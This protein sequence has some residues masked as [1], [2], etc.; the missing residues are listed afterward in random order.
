MNCW[1]SEP[2]G[3]VIETWLTPAAADPAGQTQ[4]QEIYSRF[5]KLQTRVR[6]RR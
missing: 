1:Q 3:R 2:H 6:L 5:I 4:A